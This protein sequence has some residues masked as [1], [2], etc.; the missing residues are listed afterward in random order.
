MKPKKPPKI[1]APSR[2]DNPTTH[3]LHFLSPVQPVRNYTSPTPT[4][5]PQSPQT[6]PTHLRP[7]SPIPTSPLNQMRPARTSGSLQS[8]Y[9]P[10][11]PLIQA[12]LMQ[13]GA[14]FFG[15]RWSPT[16]P[17]VDLPT[18]AQHKGAHLPPTTTTQ[19]SPQR[20]LRR[21]L[22]DQAQG[23]FPDLVRQRQWHLH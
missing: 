14:R 18:R 20:T 9:N 2:L 16:T 23:F 12:D 1:L 15:T 11:P 5:I 22:R 10:E 4:M 8:L 19:A 3:P 21:L 13:H 6:V 17:Q 7:R